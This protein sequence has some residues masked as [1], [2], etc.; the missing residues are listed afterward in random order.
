[1]SHSQLQL[2]S[3]VLT[4]LLPKAIDNSWDKQQANQKLKK[5]ARESC[6]QIAK[7]L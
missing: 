6:L 4:L 1:M 3:G 2:Q 5:K 7:M